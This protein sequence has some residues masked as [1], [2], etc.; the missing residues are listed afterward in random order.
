MKEFLHKK[1]INLWLC[2]LVL[3]TTLFITGTVFADDDLPSETPQPDAPVS[4]ELQVED[5][6]EEIPPDE[7]GVVEDEVTIDDLLPVEEASNESESTGEDTSEEAVEISPDLESSEISEIVE[8]ETNVEIVDEGGDP[9]DFASQES[10]ELISA[11]DPYWKVGTTY[12]SVVESEDDCYSGTSVGAGTCW[13]SSTPIATAL[14]KIEGGLLPTDRKL[15]VLDGSYSGDLNISGTYLSQLNGLIGVNG[16]A[17]TTII[18]NVSLNG[19]LG[20]FT[21]SG[22]SIT[23][24]VQITDSV[25]N[26]L[27]SDLNISNPDGDG[28]H[29]STSSDGYHSGTVT[30]VDVDSSGNLGTGAYI[31]ANN[32][33]K[34]TNSSF[35]SNGGEDGV[36]DAV[37][38][39]YLDTIAPGK[40]VI[41]NGVSASNNH[42]TGILINAGSATIKNVVANDNVSL[43]NTDFGYGLKLSS[44]TSSLLSLENVITKNNQSDGVN[45]E[46]NANTINMKNLETSTNG[47]IGTH[48][49]TLGSVTVNKLKAENNGLDG[50]Y[51]M[52][53]KVVTLSSITSRFNDGN[54]IDVEDFTNWTYDEI[55]DIWLG[56]VIGPSIV[57]LN[58]PKTGGGA[59]ANI[60]EGNAGYGVYIRSKGNIT[61]SNTDSFSNDSTGMVLDNCVADYNTGVCQGT[62]TVTVN[63]TIPN[64]VNGVYDNGLNGFWISSKN[65]VAIS[66]TEV[67]SN[68]EEYGIWLDTS[69]TIKLERVKSYENGKTGA[70]LDNLDGINKSVTLIDS[71]FDNNIGSG[72]EVYSR[73]AIILNAVS[74]ADNQSPVN[75]WLDYSPISVFDKVSDDM[76]DVWGIEGKGEEVTFRLESSEFDLK[77]EL[78]DG[79]NN[80]VQTINGGSDVS[81]TCTLNN[82]EI[83]QIYVSNNVAGESGGYILSVNDADHQ[84]ALYPGSGVVLDNS[85]VKANV[86]IAGSKNNLYNSFDNNDSFG[87]KVASFGT[88]SIS[89]A[90]ASGNFRTGLSLY[91]PTSTSAV[92]VQDKSLTPAS[93]FNDN[94]WEGLYIRTKGIITVYGIAAATDNG[95][96]GMNLDNCIFDDALSVCTGSGVINLTSITA[97]MNSGTGLLVNSK[98]NISLTNVS[99]N[100]NNEK[101]MVVSN[102]FNGS[103]G[104]ITL[105]SVSAEDNNDTGISLTTNGL[106]TL[107]AITTRHNFKTTGTLNDG[108]AVSEYYNADLRPDRWDFDA[109]AGV[110]LSFRL[111]PSDDP[112][113]D[114]NS[115]TGNLALFDADGVQV[116]FDS[117]NLTNQNLIATWTPSTSGHY[118]LEVIDDNVHSGFYRLS[119]NNENFSDIV[120]Y[121]VDGLSIQAGKNVTFSGSEP[122]YLNHNSLTGLFVQTPANI[123]LLNVEARSNG[124]EGAVL[125]NQSMINGIG[126]INV[127]GAS[128]SSRCVFNANGWEGLKILTNGTVNMNYLGATNNGS[129]GIKVQS[130]KTVTGRNF[131]LNGNFRSGLKITSIGMITLS[132]V[133]AG[134]NDYG[135]NLN[136]YSGTG[137]ITL[138]GDNYFI[139]NESAGLYA[140]T[141]TGAIALSGITAEGTTFNGVEART[142]LGT[143][144]L[145]NAD[146]R[147]SGYSGAYLTSDAAINLL[148]VCSWMNGSGNDGDGLHIAA[149][150]TTKVTISN[151]NFMS[152]EGNGIEIEY[153]GTRPRPVLSMIST[154]YFGNDTDYDRV[155]SEA[156]LRFSAW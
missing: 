62:G 142:T 26:I 70:Y 85:S 52:A 138:T 7:L 114:I 9:I 56:T 15:Y 2:L 54:G 104:N 89:N 23:G 119:M 3:V 124:T 112:N 102:Q 16:S 155:P 149:S 72:L 95:F 141:S 69:G 118:Y 130:Q 20:G 78:R 71:E 11:G 137:N 150:S 156:N 91:N 31:K 60:S 45:V 103:V 37:N 10:A 51:I 143:I 129:D 35:N 59:A 116:S 123:S 21:L 67:H 135:L 22:F 38:A 84:H 46:G 153:E 32:T 41:L 106:V 8:D 107:S 132:N 6:S 76:T 105:K 34:I 66:D 49:I 17:N 14:E 90:N 93:M 92:T 94:G 133:S 147:D 63:V 80:I 39:L 88:I 30:M 50:L 128:E 19:N 4:E 29:I 139:D 58:S 65:N 97:E 122:S 12:Y 148:N 131:D 61:V 13:V 25:G 101:G 136:T 18:G 42:G 24:G 81:F 146:I 154:T 73:G 151:S 40:Q 100:E 43:S 125:D 53:G 117:Y 120:T 111:Y 96:S 86:T 64:W 110:N 87:L 108:D 127:S 115:F 1:R 77:F 48:A 28:I 57:T 144:T 36:D 75:S 27:L 82:M 134:G 47:G 126:N 121:Y 55:N 113:L 44:S 83:Y 140:Y 109:Q 5:S 68:H 79:S 98:G 33:I 152:N 74:A 99:A 145:S